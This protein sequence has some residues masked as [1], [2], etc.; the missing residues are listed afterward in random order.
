MKS[1]FR[2]FKSKQKKKTSHLLLSEL[3]KLLLDS[4][5]Y[6]IFHKK[7]NEINK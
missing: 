1:Y 4:N 5:E 6:K 3:L 7:V 2:P